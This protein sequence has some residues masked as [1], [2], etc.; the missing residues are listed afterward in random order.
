MLLL[1]RF[2]CSFFSGTYNPAQT[3]AVTSS[4]REKHGLVLGVVST[5]LWSGYTLGYLFGGV[6][7]EIFGLKIAFLTGSALY[8]ISGLLVLFFVKENLFDVLAFSASA[9]AISLCASDLAIAAF[10]R[11]CSTLSIPRLSI[12]LLSST[13]F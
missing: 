4:P 13:K 7:A 11:I 3:L 1:L 6:V 9:I 10:L 2:C 8:L 5:A 12:T